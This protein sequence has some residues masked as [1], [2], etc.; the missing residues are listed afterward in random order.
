M[1]LAATRRH[2]FRGGF[3]HVPC[4]PQQAQ[5]GAPSM[6]ADDVVRGIAIVLEAAVREVA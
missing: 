3:L 5:G 1:H 6:A 2:L 4:L